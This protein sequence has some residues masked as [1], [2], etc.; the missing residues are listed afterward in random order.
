MTNPATT[1]IV[2]TADMLVRL[3]TIFAI[4]TILFS[5]GVDSVGIWPIWRHAARATS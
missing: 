3:R 1:I 5:A 4:E 2:A